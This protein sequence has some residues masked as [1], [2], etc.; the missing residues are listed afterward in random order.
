MLH[1]QCTSYAS[2]KG[3]FGT[4][5]EQGTSGEKN[6]E[7]VA[8]SVGSTFA[9]YH[10]VQR[11]RQEFDY[12]RQFTRVLERFRPDV[13][14]S[15]NDP[16][17]AKAV[18]GRWAANHDLP[19]VYWLQDLY[20]IA[21]SRAA[22]SRSWATRQ[23]AAMMRRTERSLLRRSQAVVSITE[24]F[25]PVLA[26]WGI[27]PAKITVIENW[28]PLAE[29]PLRP[30]LNAWRAGHGLDDRFV[31]LYAGT[32]GMKHN[33][34]V[35]HALAK[36]EP[37]AAVVVISEGLGADRLRQVL[38]EDP[39]DNL[40]I[41]PFQPWESLPDVFGAADVLVVL[42][43]AEA[44]EFSVPSKILT[45]LCAGRPIL[46]AM[47]AVNLGARTISISGGGI[48]VPPDDHQAFLAASHRLRLDDQL[49]EKMGYHARVHA[50]Q[51]FE[52]EAIT[53]R[54]CAVLDAVTN[55]RSIPVLGAL[56]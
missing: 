20:S 12:G 22:A 28:A 43:E 9:R 29:V 21:M 2:G 25:A 13:V 5:D 39:V 41:L 31:Y 47:P 1:V 32:L 36:A 14:I 15:C 8:I 26:G 23:L 17:I 18:F 4:S 35:L 40:H 16:L 37:E 34:D 38:N 49:R 11:V 30:R 46:A 45:S 51:M 19:W 54:F 10:L 27:D 55:R 48:V 6:P 33:P 3:S 56:H 53:D 24:D 7:Y 50:E 44:A 52:I 42:L